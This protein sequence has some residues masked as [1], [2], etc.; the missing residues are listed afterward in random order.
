MDK[1]TKIGR[2]PKAP[3]HKYSEVI[4]IK[5]TAADRAAIEAGAAAAG[6]PLT[7]WARG[8]LLRAAKRVA[9]NN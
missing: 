4:Y 8:V 7:T 2:P 1:T 6:E 3:E 5:A 9:K